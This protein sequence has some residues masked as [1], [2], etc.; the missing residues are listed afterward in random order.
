MMPIL[1]QRRSFCLWV[2]TAWILATCHLFAPAAWA[3]PAPIIP[4][5]PSTFPEDDSDARLRAL[6]EKNAELNARLELLDQKYRNLAQEWGPDFVSDLNPDM[7]FSDSGDA[8]G[9]RHVQASTIESP[10]PDYTEGMIAPFDA[11][12]GYPGSNLLTTDRYPLKA[13]FGPGF[14]LQSKDK[15]FTLR[16]HYESQIEGRVWDPGRNNPSN[17]GFFFPRQ[18]FFFDG[19][20]TKN[21]EYEIS[22]NRGVNNINILNAYLNFHFTDNLQLRIGRFFTPFNYDQYAVSN[23]W[24]LTPERSLFTTNLSLNRQI[25][26]MAWGFLLDD[27]LDYAV[28]A[29]NGSRNSFESLNNGVDGVAYLNLRP[30]Q[31]SQR[32]P[33]ARFL[34]VGTSISYGQQGQQPVPATFRIGAGSPD[35]N[36]PSTATTPFLILNPGVTEDGER[37]LGTVHMAYFYNS[38]S[39][40]S[41]WQYGHGGYALN[42]APSVNVPFSGYYVSG[43][44]FL[45]G[46]HIQRRTRLKPL[47]PL[48]PTNKGQTR[49]LGA[50]EVATRVSQ[51]KIGQEIFNAGLADPGAWSNSATTTEV[52]MNWYWNEYLKFY[53][54]W[55]HG[56]FG[57]PVQF[58][59]GEFHGSV[60]MCW[61]RCQLYF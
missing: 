3:Q 25:G 5:N 8:S 26:A 35:A 58:K 12:P 30:F 60:D 18:R 29:F 16:F 61:L 9:P 7:V 15:D 47:R 52:G 17:N 19:N 40:M 10:V 4:P 39:F 11:A 23:Y 28:G 42:S 37:L 33:W 38:L 56:E 20:I 13:T 59:P 2:I 53:A 24:L 21:L 6:E 34:N 1:T 31:E 57:D 51:L 49:G 22:V 54:F 48:L 41:E 55:L 32:Y 36:I 50:W 27:K 45:T 46:E 43:G 14:Q 44:Y